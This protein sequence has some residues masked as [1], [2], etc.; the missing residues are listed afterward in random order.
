MG[1][2]MAAEVDD[3]TII[4]TIQ[5][6]FRSDQET[7]WRRPTEADRYWYIDPPNATLM[8]VSGFYSREELHNDTFAT[9]INIAQFDL[10]L[11]SVNESIDT[12]FYELVAH[13]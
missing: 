7:P 1:M 12:A 5:V 9:N 13:D 4:G 10:T 8:R 2:P 3:T 6:G 11:V